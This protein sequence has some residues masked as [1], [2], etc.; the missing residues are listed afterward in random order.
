MGFDYFREHS[1]TNKQPNKQL[2]QVY[3]YAVVEPFLQYRQLAL[4][5][6]PNIFEINVEMIV[7]QHISHNSNDSFSTRSRVR[8]FRL[9]SFTTATT[10]YTNVVGSFNNG[11]INLA[12]KQ[13]FD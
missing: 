8:S 2:V 6:L 9:F 1:R 5:H 3:G 11:K 7:D 10:K 12:I 13:V 4:S